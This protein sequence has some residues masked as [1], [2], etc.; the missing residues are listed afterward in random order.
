MRNR[1]SNTAENIASV[2]ALLVRGLR[3]SDIA[4]GDR[5]TGAMHLLAAQCNGPECASLT[6]TQSVLLLLIPLF[7]SLGLVFK[8]GG[9]RFLF[10]F[11]PIYNA[12]VVLG[13]SSIGR[14]GGS[15]SRLSRCSTCSCTS[16]WR[17]T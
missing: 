14:R 16:S 17:V 15:C 11:V 2:R 7:A 10:A 8:K 6:G 5:K 12:I 13:E 3:G 9:Y 1:P 4:R